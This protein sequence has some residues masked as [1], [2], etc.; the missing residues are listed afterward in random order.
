MITTVPSCCGKSG[1]AA[2][3]KRGSPTG[4]SSAS[5]FARIFEANP[6][7]RRAYGVV[8]GYPNMM[9][10]EVVSTEIGDTNEDGESDAEKAAAQ[11]AA[12][13]EQQRALAPTLPTSELYERVYADPANKKLLGRAPHTA[14]AEQTPSGEQPGGGVRFIIFPP[15]PPLFFFFCFFFLESTVLD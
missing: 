9:S 13:V 15:P 1:H 12:L 14:P 4:E 11:I 10:L 8:K 3:W 7:I 5:A 6:D 2:R